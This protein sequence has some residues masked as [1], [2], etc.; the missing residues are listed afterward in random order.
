MGLQPWADFVGDPEV[1]V[2]ENS[3][4]LEKYPNLSRQYLLQFKSVL[5]K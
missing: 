4:G 5:S 2:A 3:H 1:D